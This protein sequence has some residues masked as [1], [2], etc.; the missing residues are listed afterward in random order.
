MDYSWPGNVRELRNA[1]EF[2]VIRCQR[3]IIHTEDLPPEI[4]HSVYRHLPS[5]GTYQ[6]EK[7]RLLAALE[8]ARGNRTAAARLLGMSRATFYRRLTSLGIT[9]KE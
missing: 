6:D 7:K 8:A 1:I 5:S 9:S 4:V 2:A 3:T